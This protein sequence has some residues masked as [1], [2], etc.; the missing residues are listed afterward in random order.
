[1]PREF[2]C[3]KN[4]RQVMYS[5]ISESLKYMVYTS[6]VIYVDF[7]MDHTWFFE[8]FD[9]FCTFLRKKKKQTTPHSFFQTEQTDTKCYLLRPPLKWVPFFSSLR[10]WV[11][12]SLVQCLH[13]RT[14]SHNNRKSQRSFFR[15][16]PIVIHML[17][18]YTH[19]K[20]IVHPLWIWFSSFPSRCVSRFQ[21][22]VFKAVSTS[23]TATGW[24]NPC[25]LPLIHPQDRFHQFES[26]QLRWEP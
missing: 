16:I 10:S 25:L 7:I 21:R 6:N 19:V 9:H 12:S 18:I 22:A 15:C 4:G 24:H 20:H 17:Y 11:F 8:E 23:A 5:H 26:C 2:D 13:P 1:M 14:F 3:D